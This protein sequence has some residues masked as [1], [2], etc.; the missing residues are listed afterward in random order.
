MID[1]VGI[2]PILLTPFDAAGAVDVP[3]LHRLVDDYCRSGAVSLV[4]P[5]V[6]SEVDKLA[7]DERAG[8]VREAVAA[9]AGRLPVIGGVA[10]ADAPAAVREAEA[11][12]RAGA[13]GLLVRPPAGLAG[14]TAALHAYVRAV[15]AAGADY[16]VLQDL[17]W[18]DFGLP[19]ETILSLAGAVP[20]LRAVKIEVV[21]TGYKATQVLAAAG[22]RLKVWSGWAMLQMLETLAR[23]VETYNPS[24]YH[25]PF[26][27][28]CASFRAGDR[29]AAERQ[30][31]QV[32]PYLA[33]SRQH[34]DV[35]LHL[36]KRYCVRRG[37]F[38]HATLRPPAAP[39]D[40]QHERYGA[41]LIER[42]L[43]W[44]AE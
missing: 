36:L 28:V 7:P 6:A 35:N 23:G 19:V 15:A 38:T 9:A 32:L 43:A 10:G 30:F 18:D 44:E 11:A 4:T 14:D 29:A 34:I 33:W 24:A 16:L 40:D 8:Q 20:A 27:Q 22:G 26:V 5:A 37:L 13:A 12:L 2:V 3:S 17:A 39:Y 41:A 42:M 25:R 31:E 1:P 21:R